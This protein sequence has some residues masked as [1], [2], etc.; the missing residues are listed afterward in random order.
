MRLFT[1]TVL[2]LAILVGV[3]VF[4]LGCA[5][6]GGGANAAVTVAV[7]SAESESDTDGGTAT[8]GTKASEGPAGSFVGKVT[9]TGTPAK[10][11]ALIKKGD[12]SAKDAEVCAAGDV[13]DERLVVGAGGG[14]R[15]VFI[16]M[17]KV[18]KA[19]T[20]LPMPEKALVFDQEICT[21]LP[22]AMV[23]RCGQQIKIWNSDAVAHNTHTKPKKNS[24][25]NSVV[26]AEDRSGGVSFKYKKS[27]GNP[28]PVVCDFHSWMK[29]YHL[30][31]NHPFAVVTQPDGTF[32]IKGI[33]PGKYR[34]KI[35]HSGKYLARKVIVEIKPGA[36]TKMDFSYSS[37]KLLA[38]K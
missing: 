38:T 26:K 8:T 20:K 18:P 3:G 36:E 35:W 19:L 34:F 17:D 24:E 21:F 22:H 33:P 30:P 4:S 23:V 9:V 5:D 12:A 28:I 11:A 6:V 31:V 13:P 15:D 29:A 25:F 7:K 37:E 1:S 10:L 32:E 27:E 14:V 16:Y 2:P